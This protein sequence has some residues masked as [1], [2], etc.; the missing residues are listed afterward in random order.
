MDAHQPNCVSD[1]QSTSAVELITTTGSWEENWLF[2][3]KRSRSTPNVH[4][5]VP[6]PMLVP[7]P[8]EDFRALVGG[9][10]ADDLSDMSDCSDSVLEDLITENPGLALENISTAE[11]LESHENKNNIKKI[12]NHEKKQNYAENKD[13]T[14]AKSHEKFDVDEKEKEEATGIIE[15]NSLEIPNEDKSVSINWLLNSQSITDCEHLEE[16][17]TI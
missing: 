1:E 4:H 5:P 2:Q 7:N 10:D 12:V 9:I 6:V 11:K 16:L 14:S 8:S 13:G 3:K 17:V 15:Y